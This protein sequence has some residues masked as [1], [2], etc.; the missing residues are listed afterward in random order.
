MTTPSELHHAWR[1]SIPAHEDILQRLPQHYLERK[2][3]INPAP[4]T[5]NSHPNSIFSR[6][7]SPPN[8]NPPPPVLGTAVPG[9]TSAAVLHMLHTTLVVS[10]RW[11]ANANPPLRNF[12]MLVW[13]NGGGTM[14]TTML[15]TKPTPTSRIPPGASATHT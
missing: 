3:R 11:P 7:H 4:D 5:S 15:A 14:H 8:L 1:K 12:T 10:P 2:K 9:F 13:Q 6:S